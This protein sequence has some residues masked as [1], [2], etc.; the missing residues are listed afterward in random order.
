VPTSQKSIQVIKYYE[1][2]NYKS[3]RLLW[4]N[5]MIKLVLTCGACP[6]QYDAFDGDRLVGYLRLRH[7]SFTVQCPNTL[8]QL[9][10]EASPEGDGIFT[11]DERDY[12]LRFAVDAIQRWQRGEISNEKPPAPDVE[13]VMIGNPEGWESI[14]PDGDAR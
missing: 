7:G 11:T 6:E 8:G 14:W 9:V 13:Y 3:K 4:L 10:Y 12:Y 1:I 5:K 2:V